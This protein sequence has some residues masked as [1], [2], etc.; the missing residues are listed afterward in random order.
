M[1]LN[2]FSLKKICY[3]TKPFAGK[4]A[5]EERQNLFS[6]PLL[7][8][9][10][11][12]CAEVPTILRFLLWKKKEN[13][14]SSLSKRNKHKKETTS[15]GKEE[16]NIKW[17]RN[18]VIKLHN[19][20]FFYFTRK[21]FSS[22]S[23]RKIYSFRGFFSYLFCCI[24][25]IVSHLT[26]LFILFQTTNMY[27]SQHRNIVLRVEFSQMLNHMQISSFLWFLR[28]FRCF[29]NRLNVILVQKRCIF[30][31]TFCLTWQ[32]MFFPLFCTPSSLFTPPKKNPTKNNVNREKWAEAN[33]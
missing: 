31:T 9:L 14:L 11:L 33:I 22:F 17:K 23:S 3:E 5:R 18:E 16:F 8:L 28:K 10:N 27:K 12:L 19:L 25:L 4:R 15:D 13:P 21:V 6:K 20:P 24:C 1:K 30:N 2:H 32:I 26:T 7:T 29:P